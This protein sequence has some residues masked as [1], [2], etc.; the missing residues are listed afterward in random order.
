MPNEKIWQVKV[1]DNT[2]DIDLPNDATPEIA[3]LTVNGDISEGGNFL[4]N[5]YA[6]ISHEH[7]NYL[8]LTGGTMSGTTLT[9]VMSNSIR[10]YAVGNLTLIG[11]SSLTLQEGG[12]FYSLPKDSGTLALQTEIPTLYAHYIKVKQAA[13]GDTSSDTRHVYFTIVNTISTRMDGEDLGSYLKT[14]GINQGFP[15]MATGAYDSYRVV[16]VYESRL[17]SLKLVTVASNGVIIYN[18]IIAPMSF[19]DNC[20][21]IN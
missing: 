17:T 15:L 1:G 7:G 3:G 9:V 10:L 20:Y 5:K 11:Y 4:K 2:Y 18:S 16:G 14:V 12:R 13:P 19:N 6:P 21:P 8:P